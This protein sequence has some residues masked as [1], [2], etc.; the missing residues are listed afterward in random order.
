MN[1]AELEKKVSSSVKSLVYK[2]GY[3]CAV[4]VLLLLDLITYKDYE[5]W[6]FGRVRYL[7]KVCKANLKQ[8]TLL[9]QVIRRTSRELGLKASWTAYYQFGKGVRK[10]LR[11][12]KS[13]DLRIEEHYATHY[14]DKQRIAELK[15]KQN[16]LK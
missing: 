14:L 2:K 13:G 1:R 16:D 5:D 6:R 4:D 8:L 11:F 15:G 3:A 9:N 10:R 7:E 12:S